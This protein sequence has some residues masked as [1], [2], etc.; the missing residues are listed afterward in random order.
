MMTGSFVFVSVCFCL[1]QHWGDLTLTLDV[2]LFSDSGLLPLH[3][4]LLL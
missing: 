2:S 4:M 3:W 1:L